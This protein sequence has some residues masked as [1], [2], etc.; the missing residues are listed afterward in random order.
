MERNKN[1]QIT[2]LFSI[3]I[4][5]AINIVTSFQA[6]SQNLLKSKNS[7]NIGIQIN[8]IYT[9]SNDMQLYKKRL[10][11]CLS[12]TRLISLKKKI[13][14]KIGIGFSEKGSNYDLYFADTIKN[15]LIFIEN[16]EMIKLKYLEFPIVFS[17]FLANKKISIGIG[18]SLNYLLK[19]IKKFPDYKYNEVVLIEKDINSK[20]DYPF[21]Y[22]YFSSF[23]PQSIFSLEYKIDK[24]QSII[25]ANYLISIFQ[26][27]SLYK[28]RNSNFQISYSYLF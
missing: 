16:I 11:Y 28:Y 12:Y 25:S 22:S 1:K 21:K 10:S 15:K 23:D 6:L 4:L 24:F 14:L 26:L 19:G 8:D 2:I 27:N 3:I 20:I 5:I 7:I 13:N 17:K 9:T 18:F